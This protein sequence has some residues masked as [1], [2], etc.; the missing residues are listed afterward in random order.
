MTHISLLLLYAKGLLFE[1][2]NVAVPE[3]RIYSVPALGALPR[4]DRVLTLH[5]CQLA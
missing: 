1:C 2:A 3:V 5:I 4:V